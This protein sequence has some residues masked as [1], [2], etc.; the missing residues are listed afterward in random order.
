MKN[1][2]RGHDAQGRLKK[3][4][5]DWTAEGYSNF[6]APMRMDWIAEQVKRLPRSH[7]DKD[8]FTNAVL[9]PETDTY[10][11]PNWDEMVP[12]PMTWKIRFDGFGESNYHSE[13]PPSHPYGRVTTVGL[14]DDCPPWYQPQGASH[15]GGTLA[16]VSCICAAAKVAEDPK[17]RATTKANV[18]H[19]P[20]CPCVSQAKTPVPEATQF[21]TGCGLSDNVVHK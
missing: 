18:K 9:K 1:P 21:S 13:G 17:V 4:H 2:R 14:P 8:T 3:I 6:M 16:D 20:Q 11:T 19:E 7:P 12:F 10:L 15:V 5:L